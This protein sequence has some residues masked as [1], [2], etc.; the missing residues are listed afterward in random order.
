MSDERIDLPD[1]DR[2]DRTLAKARRACQEM[3]IA[4]LELEEAMARLECQI[5]EQRLQR[6]RL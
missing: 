2:L 5:R 4:G 3:E 6:L 1:R